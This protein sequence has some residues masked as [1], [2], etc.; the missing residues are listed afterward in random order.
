MPFGFLKLAELLTPSVR[1]NASLGALRTP[2]LPERSAALD[3]IRRMSITSLHAAADGDLRTT[4]EDAMGQGRG[5]LQVGTRIPEIEIC[6]SSYRAIVDLRLDGER[7]MRSIL[8]D[9]ALDDVSL[10]HSATELESRPIAPIPS[11]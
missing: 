5:I 2:R 8:V 1:R 7:T 4:L 10:I 3:S 11:F 6:S 9:G